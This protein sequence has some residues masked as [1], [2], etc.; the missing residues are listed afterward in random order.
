MKAYDPLTAYTATPL[1]EQPSI[2]KRVLSFFIDFSLLSLTIFT[3]LSWVLEI[4]SPTTNFSAAYTAFLN[5]ETT[6]TI[7]TVLMLYVFIL[8]LLYFALLEYLV[9]QTAGMCFL[10]LKVENNA[11]QKITFWQALVRNCVFLPIFPFILFW[12]IDPA[13]L[14]FTKKRLSEQ[15]SRTRTINANT[16]YIK[17][18]MSNR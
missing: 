3:P 12:F 11:G 14:I 6:N 10:N 5:N 18:Q 2:M 17:E 13:Y 9:G 7:I 15:L 16:N 8:V 1:F 4:L